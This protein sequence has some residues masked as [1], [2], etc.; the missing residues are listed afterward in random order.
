MPKH[1]RPAPPPVTAA[2]PRVQLFAELEDM[3]GRMIGAA[4]MFAEI[5]FA[6]ARQVQLAK[7]IKEAG[8]GATKN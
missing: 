5:A 7:A 3:A 2:D 6:F 1:H 8:D 4:E